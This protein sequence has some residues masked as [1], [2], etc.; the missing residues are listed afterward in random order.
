MSVPPVT[1]V[2]PAVA[3]IAGGRTPVA[4]WHNE[5]GGRTYRIDDD[6]VKWFAGEHWEIDLPGEAE[7]MRWASAFAPVPQ[8]VAAGRDDGGQWLHTKALP[9]E[10][11]VHPDNVAE[12]E[13]TVA[14]LGRGL[15]RWHD[16]LPPPP[17]P[18]RWDVR[19]RLR[20]RG[21]EQ[22]PVGQR[23]LDATPTMETDLVVCHGDA[24]NPNFLVRGGEV[25]GYVDVGRLGIADRWADLTPA[26]A[27][28]TWN[29]GRGWQATFLDGYGIA[30][31][32]EKLDYYSRLWDLA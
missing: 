3:R 22:T 14:A 27:S 1:G 4:V 16:L 30:R 10:S 32:A 7:R 13:Q 17:C 29:F 9:G 31:D 8:V 23:Y 26:L 2:P 24:C 18:H 25:V 19:E 6:Y 15:R 21:M 12:P 20:A 11:A 5:L 28:L